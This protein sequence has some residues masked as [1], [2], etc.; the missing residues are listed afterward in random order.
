MINCKPLVTHG[1]LVLLNAIHERSWLYT[2]S[3]HSHI[4][5]AEVAKNYPGE[6]GTCK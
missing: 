6:N 2:D 1:I 3:I 4:R 5:Q